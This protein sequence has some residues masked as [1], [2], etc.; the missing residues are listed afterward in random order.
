MRGEDHPKTIS[1]QGGEE[2]NWW[3]CDWVSDEAL[4][5]SSWWQNNINWIEIC[6][7]RTFYNIP[8]KLLYQAE[9]K[10]TKRQ[11]AKYNVSMLVWAHLGN[12]SHANSLFSQVVVMVTVHQEIKLRVKLNAVKLHLERG[13]A[14]RRWMK[15]EPCS[16]DEAQ[17]THQKP[18][19]NTQR[20][21][22]TDIKNA[23]PRHPL[24][25]ECMEEKVQS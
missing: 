23:C 8:F 1:I 7:R 20:T 12:V 9:V 17:H 6:Y 25:E 11:S 19:S 10:S 21:E 13:Q 4:L 22:I 24:S 5:I 18:Y 16:D 15:E 3:R 2:E 14:E